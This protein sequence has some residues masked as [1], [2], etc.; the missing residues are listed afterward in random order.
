MPR[1]T[2]YH[3]SLRAGVSG[4]ALPSV[5]RGGWGDVSLGLVGVSHWLICGDVGAYETRMWKRCAHSSGNIEDNVK[6]VK[7]EMMHTGVNSIAKGLRIRWS[8][9]RTVGPAARSWK[10]FQVVQSS[11]PSDRAGRN[12]SLTQEYYLDWIGLESRCRMLQVTI[13]GLPI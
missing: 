6:F 10:V 4:A 9:L 3:C 13:H 2:F 7:L 11:L 5:K 12:I 1:C 8:A